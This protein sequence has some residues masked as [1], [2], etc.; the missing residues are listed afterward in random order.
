MY[1]LSP[2]AFCC[3]R[4]NASVEG[5]LPFGIYY[6]Q[7]EWFDKNFVAD[8]ATNF[9][10]TSFIKAKVIPQR[11]D[12]VKRFSKAMLWHTDGGCEPPRSVNSCWHL[13]Y[14]LSRVPAILTRCGQGWLRTST[15]TTWTG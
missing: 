12:L 15:G 13:G 3:R 5:G 7:G 9:T 2:E 8:W 14:V 11:L 1:P 4:Y 6:S 10:E